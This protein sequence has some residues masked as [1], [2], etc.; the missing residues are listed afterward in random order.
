MGKRAVDTFAETGRKSG[1]G[2]SIGGCYQA[3]RGKAGRVKRFEGTFFGIQD[4]C[5]VPVCQYKMLL[6]SVFPRSVAGGACQGAGGRLS[7]G[8]FSEPRKGWQ[9]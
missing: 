9:V 2:R 3:V 1:G 6:Q 4:V 5:G 7:S 8:P